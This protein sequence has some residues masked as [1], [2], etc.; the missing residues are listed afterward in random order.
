[1]SSRQKLRKR[2]IAVVSLLLLCFVSISSY[3]ESGESDIDNSADASYG[4]CVIEKFKYFVDWVEK[5]LKHIDEEYFKP[6]AVAS[7]SNKI[8]ETIVIEGSET[9]VVF[10]EKLIKPLNLSIPEI[11]HEGTMAL[12]EGSNINFPDMFSEQINKPS[13]KEE[14]GA[15]FG[16]RLLMDEAELEGMQEYRINNVKDAI[17]GAE[18]SLEYKTN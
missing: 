13:V 8:D 4:T 6:K 15:S 7:E 1:M 11:E 16:G 5:E 14:S 2:I 10:D 17:R 12:D 18:L 3:S 9:E